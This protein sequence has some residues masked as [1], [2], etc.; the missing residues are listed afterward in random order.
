[1]NHFYQRKKKRKEKKRKE[2]KKE[3]KKTH[4]RRSEVQQNGWKGEEKGT[5]FEC[6]G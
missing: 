6:P 2:K 5:Y 1:M 4:V 3:K